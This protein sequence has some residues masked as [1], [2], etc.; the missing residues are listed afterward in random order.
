MSCV[1]CICKKCK[2]HCDRCDFCGGNAVLRDCTDFFGGIDAFWEEDI[3]L[4]ADIEWIE[5]EW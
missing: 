3:D 5:D 2:E 4:D 1:S